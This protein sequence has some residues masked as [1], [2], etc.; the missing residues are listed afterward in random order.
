MM[1]L[2]S[3]LR[4]FRWLVFGAWL[5]TLVPAVWL[6]LTQSGH[7]T[8]GGFE[9]ADSQSLQVQYHIEDHFPEE[10][11]SP[12]ALVAA[13]RPNATFADMNSAVEELQRIAS[14]RHLW[15]D[16]IQTMLIATLPTV[17]AISLAAHGSAAASADGTPGAAS[18]TVATPP[19]AVAV[20]TAPRPR[21]L[22]C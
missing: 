4:R 2:S 16:E 19:T 10:G 3:N 14:R 1:R 18:S 7:L 15:W 17:L 5:L 6:A 22:F 11:A 9:V 21:R 8:G 13:P 12:L 20:K